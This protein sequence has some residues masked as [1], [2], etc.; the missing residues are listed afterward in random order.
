MTP[1]LSVWSIRRTSNGAEQIRVWHYSAEAALKWFSRRGFTRTYLE[2][3][4]VVDRPV[5]EPIDRFHAVA[6]PALLEGPTLLER[7]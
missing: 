5:Y 1:S 6:V 2:N 3:G 4:M 7:P